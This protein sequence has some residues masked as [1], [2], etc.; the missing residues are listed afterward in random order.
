[1]SDT[2]LLLLTLGKRADRTVITAARDYF[3][4]R[5]RPGSE[6]LVALAFGAVPINRTGSPRRSLHDAITW[7]RSGPSLVIYP[8]GMIPGIAEDAKRL[9]RGVALLAREARCAVIHVRIVG[10]S[11]LLPAGIHWPRR[12][13]A[14]ITFLAPL[15]SVEGENTAQFTERLSNALFHVT[16]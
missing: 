2:P 9:H 6:L 5:S 14:H 7:L 16:T 13:A 15:L 10:A 4:S 8:H 12:A 3:F 1:M 11:T